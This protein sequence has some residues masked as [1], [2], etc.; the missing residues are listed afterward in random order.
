MEKNNT[1]K[2]ITGEC[3]MSYEH[4]WEPVSIDGNSP[5][6]YSACILIR[7]D[8][9]ATLKKFKLAQEAAVQNGIKSKWRGK[10]PA[11]LKL[12]LRD[13]DTERPEDEAFAGCYFLN[14][15]AN[16]APGIVD[17]ARNP[18]L[19]REEVYSGCYCRFS[20]NLYPFSASGNNGVAVGLNNVQKVRDGERLA[21][22]SRAE[23]DFNDGYA[24]DSDLDDIL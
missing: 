17:L 16:R 9:T 13:G 3:R 6:K 12:P 2:V 22:S 19:D 11:N 24:G 14:A 1:T 7:K 8:D 15:N 20:I 23:D 5:K 10:K 4:V 18:I 21:G